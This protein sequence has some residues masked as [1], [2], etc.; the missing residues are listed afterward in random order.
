[1]SDFLHIATI[2]LCGMV[3][4]SLQLSLGVLILLHRSSQSH[5]RR[6]KTRRLAYSF[7]LG[8]AAICFLAVSSACFFISRTENGRLS[9]SSLAV[10]I[11]VLL[12]CAIAMW[13]VYYRRGKNTQLWLPKNFTKFIQKRAKE[14]SDGAEAFSL[15]LVSAF[16]EMPISLALFIVAANS[17]LHLQDNLATLAAII[18]PFFCCIPLFIMRAQVSSG[19][20][21]AEVQRWRIK[22]KS[23][24]RVVS[25]GGFAVLAAFI[26]AFWVVQ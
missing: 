22:N 14:C 26:Y 7:I 8:C 20:N 1:M 12:G 4:I 19:K 3:Q 10:I 21:L 17:I 5:H 24:L 2:V 18:Y 16:A 11:G 13:A 25:G 9:I 6:R 23:F 15:G